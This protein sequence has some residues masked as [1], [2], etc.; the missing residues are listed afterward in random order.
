MEYIMRQKETSVPLLVRGISLTNSWPVLV[1]RQSQNYWW[2][3]MI[4][5]LV[6]YGEN[7]CGRATKIYFNV[8]RF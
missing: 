4:A 3:I 1:S 2:D 6:I 8:I 5:N 7:I